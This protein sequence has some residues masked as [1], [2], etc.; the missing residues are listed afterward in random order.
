M[1]NIAQ[2]VGERRREWLFFE[3]HSEKSIPQT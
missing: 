3:F 1:R 2:L